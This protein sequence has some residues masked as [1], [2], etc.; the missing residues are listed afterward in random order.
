M[1]ALAAS[2]L[3]PGKKVPSV[4][5]GIISE[6]IAFSAKQLDKKFK[7]AADFGV[8]T[9]KKNGDTIAEY[10]T[11]IKSHLDNKATFEHETYLLVPE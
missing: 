11:A 2:V 4:T 5:S 9:T 3:L 10:Q 7:H 1:G 8:T 6:S